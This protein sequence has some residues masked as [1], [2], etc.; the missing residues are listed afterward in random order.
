MNLDYVSV[1]LVLF[2]IAVVAWGIY[3]EPNY[4]EPA[5]GYSFDGT[6]GDTVLCDTLWEREWD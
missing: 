1:G 6:Q 2:F 4:R 5:M 3:V